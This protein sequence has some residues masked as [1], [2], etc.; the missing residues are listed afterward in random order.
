MMKKLANLIGPSCTV[1]EARSYWSSIEQ[2]H[3][4]LAARHVVQAWE[5]LKR[6]NPSFRSFRKKDVITEA[7]RICKQERRRKDKAAREAAEEKKRRRLFEALNARLFSRPSKKEQYI[8][9][10]VDAMGP[11][12]HEVEEWKNKRPPVS[13]SVLFYRDQHWFGP[14]PGGR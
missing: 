14:A 9:A 6:E 4:H 3:T 12:K 8:D 5:F 7:L 11:D 1:N 10:M 13:S 2:E